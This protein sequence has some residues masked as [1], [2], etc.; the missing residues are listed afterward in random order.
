MNFKIIHNSNNTHLL[1][2][3][4]SLAEQSIARTENV[5]RRAE[6]QGGAGAPGCRGQ[7]SRDLGLEAEV[8]S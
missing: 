7:V 1:I 8:L 4:F 6:D 2:Q 3:H 5:L